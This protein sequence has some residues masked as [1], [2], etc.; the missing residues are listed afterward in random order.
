VFL[1]ASVPGSHFDQEWGMT[2]V[3]SLLRQ[4]CCIPHTESR[5]WPLVVQASS[6]GSYGKDPKLWLTGDFLYNFTKMKDQ[7]RLLALPPELKF[8][9]PSF[10]NVQQSHDGLL[11]GGCLPYA[12]EIHTKQLWLNNFLYQWRATHTHRNRAMP[13]IKSYTRI[14][15]SASDASASA[16]SAAFYLLTSANVSKAAWGQLNRGNGALRIL[17][18][19]AGVLF[20]PKFVINS[21][22]FPLQGANRLIIP[23]DLPPVKYTDSMSPWVSDYLS[24]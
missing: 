18:Y 7:P 8:I 13:H 2:R 24:R 15:T 9:Y 6:I 4:H 22:F 21:D 19:E 23:Y 12:A 20:L 16:T 3:G 17:S 11:G 10:E 14:N 5:Q 1:V